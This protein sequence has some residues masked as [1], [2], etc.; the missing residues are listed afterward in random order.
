MRRGLRIALLA[1]G[2]LLVAA[3]GFVLWGSNPLPP[4]PEAQSAL[5]SDAQ[6]TVSTD[7]WLVFS[8]SVVQPS[9]GLIL[10]PGGHVDDH[11]YAPTARQ[12]AARGYLVVVVPMPLSLAVLDAGAAAN[13][14]AA[15]PQIQHWAVGGH[16]LGGAMAAH[17][18]KTH[19]GVS[20]GLVLWASYPASSDSLSSSALRVVSIS[21]SLDGLTTPEKI[22][23]SRALLP[24]DTSW[25]VIQGGNHAQF[26]WYGDQTGDNIAAISRQDQ[27]AQIVQATVDLLESIK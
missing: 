23:A 6:V 3:A 2:L 13:V 5:V 26:G 8:P 1:V 17:F 9:T 14:M 7:K 15:Y 16:S 22:D 10:Y 25:V 18:V 20:D 27:Q 12:I 11:A 19:P 4:M 24:A 21:A